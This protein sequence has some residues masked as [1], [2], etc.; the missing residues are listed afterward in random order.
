MRERIISRKR[1]EST[2]MRSQ[3]QMTNRP[4]QG[5][6]MFTFWGGGFYAP[7][8]PLWPKED[9]GRVAW[10]RVGEALPMGQKDGAG[11]VMRLRMFSWR[12]HQRFPVATRSVE[13]ALAINFS[14]C[15]SGCAM[16]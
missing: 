15:A 1:R 5:Q 7:K 2:E 11:L 14:A 8:A 16:R 10:L 13:N 6:H 9:E 3:P 12:T 4:G